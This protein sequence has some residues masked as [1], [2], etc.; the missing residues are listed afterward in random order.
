[1]DDMDH[2]MEVQKTIN[3]MGFQASSQ[4]EWL[5][6]SQKQ[7]NM[8]QAV[9]G[10]IGAVSLFVAAIGIA[11]TMMMSIYERT[12]EIG[13]IKVLGCAM[14]NIRNMFLIEAGFIG[15]V[16]GIIGLVLSYLISFLIN[17]FL[18]AALLNGMESKLSV[19]PLWLS[20]AAVGFAVLIGMAAGF[21]PALRAMKLSPLAAIRN[22]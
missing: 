16:G 20:A 19:I 13:V 12:K 15:F 8:V 3:N 1:M 6:Q 22:E 7:S 21:F 2:V 5:E 9:L 14:S 11:N 18:A 17:Q 10:G 4:M